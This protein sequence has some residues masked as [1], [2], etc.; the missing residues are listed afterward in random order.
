MSDLE[1]NEVH[2]LRRRTRSSGGTVTFLTAP[3]SVFT[4][5]EPSEPIIY[6]LPGDQI[7]VAFN[8]DLV[9]ARI[10]EAIDKVI[11]TSMKPMYEFLKEQEA[12]T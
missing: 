9:A 4:D 10:Y 3:P 12:E 6:E 1:N 8:I 2:I 5:L 11:K 7:C